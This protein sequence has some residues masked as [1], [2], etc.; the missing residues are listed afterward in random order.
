MKKYI[1]KL[2]NFIVRILTSFIMIKD[3][4]KRVRN[5]LSTSPPPR[6]KRCYTSVSGDIVSV[7]ANT[8]IGCPVKIFNAETRIGKFCS[9]AWD[10]NIGTTH[11]PTNWLTTHIFPYSRRPDLYDIK[12]DDN[13]ILQ[14]N[15][16]EPVYIGNDVWIGCD[17]TIL[18]GITIGD[19]AIVGAGSIVTKDIP[20]YA[21]VGGAPAKIIR[22]RFD[23]QTIKD[24]LL[25]KWWD[26]DEEN[27][28]TLPF[29]N[30]AKCIDKLK[31]I[32]K[33]NNYDTK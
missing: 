17:V 25:L 14:Y 7:G 1:V 19:G 18:D 20:P 9:I 22:Y 30:V 4:R 5:F 3:V 29:D 15:Y 21:I 13:Q 12:L 11:H 24:L 31:T 8:Y 28:K 10:V 32:R 27:I 33:I 16:V 6:Q 23:E 2:H 26:L